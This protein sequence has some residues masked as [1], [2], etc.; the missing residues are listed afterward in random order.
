MRNEAKKPGP[1]WI[2]MAY[3]KSTRPI[4]YIVGERE[5]RVEG[6]EGHSNEENRRYAELEAEYLD[7]SEEVPEPDHR[8]EEENRVC[9]EIFRDARDGR[10]EAGEYQLLCRHRFRSFSRRPRCPVP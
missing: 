3:T 5:A 6:A 10:A 2:P 9:G 1:D 7:V 4:T 8:E